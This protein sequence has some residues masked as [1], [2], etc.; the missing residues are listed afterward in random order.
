MIGISKTRNRNKTKNYPRARLN[1]LP[2]RLSFYLLFFLVSPC[3]SGPLVSVVISEACSRRMWQGAG[4]ERHTERHADRETDRQ[5][6]GDMSF[7]DS[8]LVA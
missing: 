2:M 4:G 3:L 1:S 7:M 8:L 6:D 5:R